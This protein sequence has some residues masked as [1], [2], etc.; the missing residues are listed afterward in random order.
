[1]TTPN[2]R[3]FNA[4]WKSHTAG[5]SPYPDNERVE[6]FLAGCRIAEEGN[7][8]PNCFNQETWDRYNYVV[9]EPVDQTVRHIMA[10]TN[11]RFITIVGGEPLDQ[12]DALVELCKLLKENKFHIIVFSHYTLPEI[13]KMADDNSN[14]SEL[15]KHIDI[16]IDGPY[17]KEFH[18]Y[19][20]FN[21]DGLHNAVGSGNQIIWDLQDGRCIGYK[22]S[23]LDVFAIGLDGVPIFKFIHSPMPERLGI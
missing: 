18:I 22:S 20:E 8:C 2:I 23:E 3:I 5:P 21:N 16:L 11:N 19:D 13:E 7:P 14:Y 9:E 12:I 15:L 1:M 4:K 10:C 17:K 6:L